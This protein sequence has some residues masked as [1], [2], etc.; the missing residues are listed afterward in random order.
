MTQITDTAT[1]ADC[2]LRV[3]EANAVRVR[4]VTSRLL[5]EHASLPELLAVRPRTS[6]TEAR[7]DL[8][9]RTVEIGRAHV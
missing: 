9:P 8:Q 5:A 4:Q 6:S 1:R 7:V 3:M 2:A